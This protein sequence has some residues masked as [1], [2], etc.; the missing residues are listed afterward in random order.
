MTVVISVIVVNYNGGDYL[1]R[2]VESLVAQS[3]SDF[4]VILVDNASSDGSIEDLPTLP[5]NF[6]IVRAETNIGFAAANNLGASISSGSWLALLN[7]DA[8]ASPEWLTSLLRAVTVRPN[9]RVVASAQLQLNDEDKLDGVGDCYS[10]VGFAWRGG[11]GHSREIMPG[12]GEVFAACGASAFYPK[13]AFLAAGGFDESFFCYLEDV[14]LG[15]RLRLSGEK[16]QFS[17]ECRIVHA[18]AAITGPESDFT[19]FHS[20]RN[21]FWTAIKNLPL[22][23]LIVVMPIWGLAVIVLYL[24]A[25]K[26]KRQSLRHGLKA[27]FVGIGPVLMSRK[28]I[29][30]AR[31]VD[32]VSVAHMISWNIL[33]H[34]RHLPDV[35]RF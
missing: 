3:F 2:C 21:T 25:T 30:N 4:E 22:L 20:I 29:Q 6:R 31:T 12:P 7:P 16:C 15:F 27:A 13:D 34:K 24:K 32:S 8:I 35:R 5:T 14:D 26:Q 17:P 33:A 18:G 1:R 9:Y 10:I 23:L 19:I 28:I 11:Y